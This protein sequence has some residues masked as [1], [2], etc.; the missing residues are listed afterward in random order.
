MHWALLKNHQKRIMMEKKSCHSL[1]I[2]VVPGEKSSKS[3]LYSKMSESP[4]VI[5][6][7]SIT[8]ELC[9]EPP[10][11]VSSSLRAKKTCYMCWPGKKQQT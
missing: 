3:C 11:E 8:V 6:R 7:I 2:D 1:P 9:L 10:S 5:Y 4:S